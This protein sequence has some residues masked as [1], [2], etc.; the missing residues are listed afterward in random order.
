MGEVFGDE[1]M[2]KAPIDRPVRHFYIVNIR[3]NSYPP[4]EPRGLYN[5]RR[6]ST[7]GRKRGG[8]AFAAPPQFADAT[9]MQRL[10]C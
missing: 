3:G 6:G 8:A 4:Q 9:R 1:V 5:A 7:T 2:A 10:V